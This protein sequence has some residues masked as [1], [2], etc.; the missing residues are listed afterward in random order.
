M[1]TFASRPPGLAGANKHWVVI[2]IALIEKKK[3]SLCLRPLAVR[4][5]LK[6]GSA[7]RRRANYVWVRVVISRDT[8]GEGT[9]PFSAA[10]RI[11]PLD[12]IY[13]GGRQW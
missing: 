1:S 3:K 11:W 12:P 10:A 6:K 7:A 5:V 13:P 2:A 9:F 4:M 8:F